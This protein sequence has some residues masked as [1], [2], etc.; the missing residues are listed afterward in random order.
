M[1]LSLL[2]PVLLLSLSSA[3]REKDGRCERITIPMCADMRYNLTRMPN[4]VGHRTQKDAAAQVQEFIPL[5]QLGCSRLLKFF[6]CS[7]YA[8]M[9]T[10]QVDETLVIPACRSM[11]L[12]VKSQVREMMYSSPDR[13]SVSEGER[14]TRHHSCLSTSRIQ[15][16]PSQCLTQPMAMPLAV[17]WLCLQ[18]AVSIMRQTSKC[19]LACLKS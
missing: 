15:I 5:V 3:F 12:E 18:Q 2:S 9:C 1:W 10:E 16:V 14:I 17:V 11:C 19:C 13:R 4:L 6:L 8:P 7:L